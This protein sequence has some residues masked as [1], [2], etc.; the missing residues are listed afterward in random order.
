MSKV[1]G[2]AP[3]LLALATALPSNLIEQAQ[4][5]EKARAFFGHRIDHYEAL[6]RVFTSTGIERRYS[7]VPMTWFAESHGWPDRTAC[8]VAG[9]SQLFEDVVRKALVAAGLDASEIDAVVTVSST[10]ISTPSLEARV[11]PRLGFR[12]DVRRIPIFG[13]GCAGGVAGFA[14]ASRI[15]AS[16]P[17]TTVLLV[18]IELCTLAFRMDRATKPDIISA[19]LFGD[20]A[21]AAIF[22]SGDGPAIGRAGRATEHL[23]EESLDIMGW[24]TDE[25]GLGVILSRSLP[26]FVAK[27][28]R[29]VFDRAIERLGLTTSDIERVVC[30]PGGTKVLEA[31]EASLELRAGTFDLERSV[32]RDFGNMSS[33][34]VLFV[35]ERL[36]AQGFAGTAV[37]AALGPGFTAS[38]AT[39]HVADN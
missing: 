14:N 20:G 39:L 11:L 9:A 17:G 19:A 7:V 4:A 28:Y 12:P 3:Q 31:I 23:W 16:E 37:L 18:T 22:R 10:G 27:N 32:M 13:L 33:P 5:A 25:A 2:L 30:H 26:E 36:L 34:T 29:V 35:L 1:P 21:A 6:S 15:A 38:F 8:Y 24:S